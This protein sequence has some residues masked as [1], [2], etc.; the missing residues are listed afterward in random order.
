MLAAPLSFP[1][2]SLPRMVYFLLIL[3]YGA[4]QEQVVRGLC[5]LRQMQTVMVTVEMEGAEYVKR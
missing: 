5:A 3:N 1:M 4:A 2:F